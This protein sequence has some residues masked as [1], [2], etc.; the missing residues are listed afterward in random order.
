[1]TSRVVDFAALVGKPAHPF[2]SPVRP[3]LVLAW[4]EQDAPN[5]APAL[6]GL[7]GPAAARR[8]RDVF[9]AALREG[10]PLDEAAAE[11]ELEPAEIGSAIDADAGLA[12]A[13]RIAQTAGRKRTVGDLTPSQR[14]RLLTSG[15]IDKSENKS[16][17]GQDYRD[18][19]EKLAAVLA[20]EG[21]MSDGVDD[22]LRPSDARA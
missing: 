8:R 10:F 22:L 5:A 16:D 9:L 6:G 1:M 2:G 21:A 13:V 12:R 19:R 4:L 18:M 11:V 20:E 7:L 17:A 3:E 15:Q 14:W